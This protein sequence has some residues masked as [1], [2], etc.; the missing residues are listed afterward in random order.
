MAYGQ[1]RGVWYR[2]R[3]VVTLMWL[4]WRN[5]AL[6]RSRDDLDGTNNAR[7]RLISR[8]INEHCRTMC[9]YKCE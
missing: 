4:R 5:L 9:D 1:R 7:E 2:M 8:W 6:D 3:I